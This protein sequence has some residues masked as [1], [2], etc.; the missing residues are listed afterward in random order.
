[1]YEGTLF[2]YLCHEPKEMWL[3][4]IPERGSAEAGTAPLL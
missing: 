3:N 4:H 1:M 2:P